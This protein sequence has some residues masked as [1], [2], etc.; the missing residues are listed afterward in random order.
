LDEVKH[1]G[2]PERNFRQWAVILL[3]LEALLILALALFL[4]IK[5]LT[6]HVTEPLAIIGDL[7]FCL[8]GSSGLFFASRGFSQGR[9]YGRA[10]AVLA[11]GIALG[12]SYFMF[13]GNFFIA[14]IP[15]FFLALAT[16]ISALFGYSENPS[17]KA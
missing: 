12:V 8:L 15:L 16:F 10:P 17:K 11:N 2:V 13:K 7:L 3:R 1:F 4:I 14:A 6:S 5:S 9:A